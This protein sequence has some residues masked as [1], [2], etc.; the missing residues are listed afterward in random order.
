MKLNQSADDFEQ[1]GLPLAGSLAAA[2]GQ[3]FDHVA[4]A[5]ALIEKLDAEYDL[6][7]CGERTTLEAL[8]T[9]RL[10][11]LGRDVRAECADGAT[12]RGRLVAMTFDS[13]ELEQQDGTAVTLAPETVRALTE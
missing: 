1:A 5:D 13:I 4:V 3:T 10:G 7:L 11:L 2:T 6:L 9:W 12:H 8:W